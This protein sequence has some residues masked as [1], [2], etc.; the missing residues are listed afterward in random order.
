M[1]F[2]AVFLMSPGKDRSPVWFLNGFARGCYVYYYI[3]CR[4]L[5]QREGNRSLC[6]FWICMKPDEAG[7]EETA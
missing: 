6:M 4:I 5:L 7:K 1:L 2:H 3:N